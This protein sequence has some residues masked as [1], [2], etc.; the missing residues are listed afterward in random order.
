MSSTSIFRPSGLSALSKGAWAVSRSAVAFIGRALG[1]SATSRIHL[2]VDTVESGDVNVGP[3]LRVAIYENLLNE[4]AKTKRYEHVVP[5]GD[6]N[7]NGLHDLLILKTNSC[8]RSEV[9]KAARRILGYG[10]GHNSK[11]A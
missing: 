8:G 10:D 3:D 1:G 7:A 2:H 5:D 9:S 4:L 6:R 11:C